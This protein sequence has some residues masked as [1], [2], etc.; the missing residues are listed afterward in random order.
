MG[1]SPWGHKESEMTELLTHTHSYFTLVLICVFL[2]FNDAEHPF[3]YLLVI[4]MSSLE[5]TPLQILHTLFDWTF[6]YWLV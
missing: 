5:K 4:C 3:M 2:M 1:Y 6:C